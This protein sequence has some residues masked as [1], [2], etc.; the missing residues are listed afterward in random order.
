MF[1]DLFL[2]WESSSIMGLL[3]QF[4]VCQVLIHTLKKKNE[5]YRKSSV[6][7]KYISNKVIK[8]TEHPLGPRAMREHTASSS[9]PL[10]WTPGWPL[11]NRLCTV[12][13]LTLIWMMLARTMM[14][15]PWGPLSPFHEQR[16]LFQ[17]TLLWQGKTRHSA[18][19]LQSLLF[20]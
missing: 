2:W 16:C 14:R 19:C 4:P 11:G 3:F 8:L 10:R 20:S 18:V 5:Q 12:P 17:V 7:I 6:P 15:W 13:C 1:L 9:S